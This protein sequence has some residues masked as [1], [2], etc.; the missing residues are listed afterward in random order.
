MFNPYQIT[1]RNFMSFGNNETKIR[2]DFTQPTLI[3]GRNHDSAVDG[4]LDSNGAGKTTVLNAITYCL[5]D[6]IIAG[7]GVKSDDLI[8]NINKKNLY[9]GMV[10][11]LGG[12]TFYKVERFRKN[13]EMG[14]TGVRIFER[15]GGK[16]DD[17][18]EDSHDITPARDH[19]ST[20]DQ[21]ITQILK[22]AFEVFSRIVAFSATHNPFL[23]LGLA[24]QTEIVEEICGL[25]ELSEKAELLK[26][27]SK[28]DKQ[29]LE[30]LEEINTTIKNQ[31]V[32]IE[33][34][35]ASA[36]SKATAWDD[37]NKNRISE[38]TTQ[39]KSLDDTDFDEQVEL[40]EYAQKLDTQIEKHRTDHR[41]LTSEKDRLLSIIQKAETWADNHAKRLDIATA[42]LNGME[43]IDFAAARALF[44]ELAEVKERRREAEAALSLA[45]GELAGINK[46]L[47]EKRGELDHLRDAKCP[48][49]TQQFKDAKSKIVGIESLVEMT[50]QNAERVQVSLDSIQLNL[51]DYVASIDAIVNSLPFQTEAALVQYERKYEAAQREVE[52]CAKETNP[53]GD[54]ELSLIR[55]EVVQLGGDIKK[56]DKMIQ[57]KVTA[58]GEVTEGLLYSSML[59]LTRDKAKAETLVVELERVC[60]A[61]N[62][63]SSTVDELMNISLEADKDKE[64]AE[65]EDLIEHQQFLIKLL[66]KKDSFVRKVLLQKSLPFMNTRLRY[67]LD[68]LGLQHKVGFQEDMTV[69]ISQ[70]GNT[71]G[72]GNLSSGQKARI[73]LALSFTFRDMLQ[74]RFGRLNFCILDECL[75]VGLGNVGVQLAAKMIKSVATDEKLSMFVISHRDEIAN[76]FDRKMVIELEGG[77]SNVVDG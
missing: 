1:I 66:T 70:F 21:K 38:I 5:Y 43:V 42:N 71:I 10:F 12:D 60:A 75:D 58:R 65:V 23:S 52:A 9:V 11:S 49:C 53:Y 17:E 69:R 44:A 3:V 33:T 8:N 16:W 24:E 76:M 55:D 68:R 63:L 2:L 22:M 56:L 20:P 77:F 54:A 35:I 13:K 28:A 15:V 4:Q 32:Q 31:R 25:T 40:F 64:I 19:G 48:Y 26:K 59:D 7:K 34:Q 41:M 51:F 47:T 74:A 67:Y 36:K 37:D 29:N 50:Q 30:R 72:F 39:L 45:E 62:P 46:T 61:T 27:Q 73:N 18:F 57:K 6:S 14:G